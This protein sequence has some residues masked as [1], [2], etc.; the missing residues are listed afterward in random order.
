LRKRREH[1][2]AFSHDLRSATVYAGS[3]SP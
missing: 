1:D 2:I 3:S